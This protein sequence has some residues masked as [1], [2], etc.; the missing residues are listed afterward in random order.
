MNNRGIAESRIYNISKKI[1]HEN[2]PEEL[3]FFDTIWG[4]MR[5]HISQ[6]DESIL[7]DWQNK[8][9]QKR[10]KKELGFLDEAEV[11]EINTPK[12]LAL[13]SLVWLRLAKYEGQIQDA[14]IEETIAEY[15]KSLPEW[16]RVKTIRLAV[17]MIKEDLI[18]IGRFPIIEEEEEK[19][20][21]MYSHDNK[22]G[23]PISEDELEKRKLERFGYNI[24][25]DVTKKVVFV[26][27]IKVK[28]KIDPI[29]WR[30]LIY[31]IKKKGETATYKEL[32]ESFCKT[33]RDPK[34]YSAWHKSYSE[35]VYR[36][37]SDI[38]KKTENALSDFVIT[39]PNEGY[40]IDTE[41]SDCKYC[42]IEARHIE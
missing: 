42:L 28:I 23:K 18:K 7:E 8:E 12:V 25:M 31:L 10:L 11:S 17:P 24:W 39:I 20:Y 16:L 36:W 35:T 33:A 32:Y 38:H 4:V 13:I 14:N 19:K 5:D 22:N 21:V 1:V 2:F 3:E 27:N 29:H 40:K 37:F 26:K 15:G 41:L 34:K 6:G 9:Y 30:L